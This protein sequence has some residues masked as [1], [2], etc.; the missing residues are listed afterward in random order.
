MLR[1]HCPHCG[2]RDEVEFRYR[3]DA[4]VARPDPGAGVDAFLDYV[5]LRDNPQGAHA[6]WWQ[7]V[8]GCRQTLRVERDTL[9]HAITAVTAARK[10]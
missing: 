1:I 7:H 3:G 5:Y 6:E 2:S 10:R 4:T 8:G 9:T